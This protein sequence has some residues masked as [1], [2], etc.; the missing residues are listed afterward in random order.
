MSLTHCLFSSASS[1]VQTFIEGGFS[2]PFGNHSLS[3]CLNNNHTQNL[4]DLGRFW[5]PLIA[6]EREL[7]YADFSGTSWTKLGGVCVKTGFIFLLVFIFC[8]IPE[9]LLVMT[10]QE[11]KCPCFPGR[12]QWILFQLLCKHWQTNPCNIP[13]DRK[14]RQR[15]YIDLP[16]ATEG[17]SV[18]GIMNRAYRSKEIQWA[19][20]SSCLPVCFLQQ[21]TTLLFY[22]VAFTGFFS[23]GSCQKLE[24][25]PNKSSWL[26]Y[27]GA[28]DFCLWKEFMFLLDFSEKRCCKTTKAQSIS[29]V[30]LMQQLSSMV[31]AIQL[32]DLFLCLCFQSS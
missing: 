11:A 16:K 27:I 24:G 15:D 6:V 12:I 26:Y 19:L 31:L 2:V 28:D 23:K 30:K 29:Q 9:S 8:S 25:N 4:K 7:V 18:R 17:I 21:R 1:L 20:R 5:G 14:T 22:Y 32:R 13:R 3:F 10:S